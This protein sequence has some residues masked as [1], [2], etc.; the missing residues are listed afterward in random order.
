MVISLND[1]KA[2][3]MTL[4]SDTYDMEWYVP[5]NTPLATNDKVWYEQVNTPLD[6]ME[7]NDIYQLIPPLINMTMNVLFYQGNEHDIFSMHIY[8]STDIVYS[9]P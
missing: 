5:I 7:T 4:R 2:S 8:M 9:I 3:F 1:I 6:N